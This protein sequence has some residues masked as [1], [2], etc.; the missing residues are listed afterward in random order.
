MQK[1]RTRSIQKSVAKYGTSKDIYIYI[2]QIRHS[3]NFL[4]F[5][6]FHSIAPQHPF[7]VSK[8]VDI[9]SHIQPPRLIN[10]H[11]SSISAIQLSRSPSPREL[12][13]TATAA[14]RV[15]RHTF[16]SRGKLLHPLNSPRTYIRGGGGAQRERAF[17]NERALCIF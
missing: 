16:G 9:I 8:I 13:A 11:P 5:P 4:S 15:F 1:C 12:E 7:D 2:S 14:A 6:L 10:F 17:N 3:R